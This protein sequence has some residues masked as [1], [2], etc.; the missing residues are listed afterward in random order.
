MQLLNLH[1]GGTL[2]PTS[3]RP[4]RTALDH[5]GRGRTSEH[6]IAVASGSALFGAI[7]AV[8]RVSSRHR[9]AVD[10]WRPASGAVATAPDGVVEAIEAEGGDAL[11]G[12]EWH[13]IRRDRRRRLRL[14]GREGERMSSVI[15]EQLS[16]VH[17]VAIAAPAW[18]LSRA[19]C[20]RAGSASPDRTV[21]CMRR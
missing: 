9:Q 3:A 15:P 4:S 20:T 6:A 19:C 16:H 21:R 5:G 17:L 18:V 10:R 8:A 13:R 7:G 11:L 14:A 12:V 1:A 2:L